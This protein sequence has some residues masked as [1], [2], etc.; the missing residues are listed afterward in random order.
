[1]GIKSQSLE[2]RIG[3]RDNA[4]FLGWDEQTKL[5]FKVGMEIQSLVP[6]IG[7]RE[8]AWFQG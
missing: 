8:K 5:G 6:R 3:W 4:W 2:P 1:M 7:C